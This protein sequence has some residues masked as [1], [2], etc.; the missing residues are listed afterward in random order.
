MAFCKK[1]GASSPEKSPWN[2]RMPTVSFVR[3]R[4]E[5][6]KE[7][8][9][10]LLDSIGGLGKPFYGY[11]AAQMLPAFA[12]HLKSDLSF[13]DCILDDNPAREGLAYPDLVP[14]IRR[15]WDGLDW[16]QAGVLITALDSAPPILKRLGEFK[17]GTVLNP[18][19]FLQERAS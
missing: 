9:A 18:L 11:G 10:V 5:E 19:E 14:R 8:L 6:F 2:F 17:A 13:L 1:G 16:Q 3:E 4:F 7:R 12:Y 15:P